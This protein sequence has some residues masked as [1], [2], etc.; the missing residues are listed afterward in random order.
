MIVDTNVV[1]DLMSPDEEFAEASAE[2][3]RAMGA[4]HRPLVNHIVFAEIAPHF[5][6]AEMVGSALAAL[7][8]RIE[9]LSDASAHRAGLAFAEYRRRGGRREAILPDFLIGAHADVLGVPIM[10]R[11]ASRF[12]SYFPDVELIVPKK[13][14]A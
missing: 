6:S 2:A 10:T 13:T 3:Y 5:A 8:M 12:R 7:G 11:D 4:S 1:F 9:P 14:D